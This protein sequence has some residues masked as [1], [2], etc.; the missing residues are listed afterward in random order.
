MRS[1]RTTA[2]RACLAAGV[3]LWLAAG[4]CVALW[5]SAR[6][7][8]ATPLGRALDFAAGEPRT[9]EAELPRGRL[10]VGDRVLRLDDDKLRSC[11]EVIGIEGPVGGVTVTLALYPD[12]GLPDPLPEGTRLLRLD[13]RGTL[14]WAMGR[15]LSSERRER[16]EAELRAMV[17]E[18]E[19]WLRDAFGPVLEEFARGVVADILAELSGFLQTH[20]AELREVGWDVLER[21]RARWEPLLRDLIW[22]RVVDR[23]RPMAERLGRELWSELPWGEIASSAARAV[24]ATVANVFLPSGYELPA[25][26]ILRWRDRYLAGTAIP[27]VESYL[28]EALEAVGEALAEAAEDERIQQALRD[29]LFRD[30]LADPKVTGLIAQAFSAAVLANPRLRE[31]VQALLEDSRVRRALFDLAEQIEPRLVALARTF[32]LDET[33]GSLHPELAMLARVRLIGSEGTWVLLELPDPERL[34]TGPR[35]AETA[36][37]RGAG[38]VRLRIEEYSGS[39]T[40]VWE[41]PLP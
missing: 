32:L 38:T 5:A 14:E 16:L 20:E 18:R 33:G 6:R 35:H 40:E 3:C 22:P 30:T 17:T 41:R 7:G 9:V 36:A 37:A 10:S 15:V 11:G 28:P 34:E 39:R 25:D 27:K 8:A 2:R 1:R 26:Q 4:V 31:R 19:G 21:A 12:A 13:A 24:G 29:T 23:L